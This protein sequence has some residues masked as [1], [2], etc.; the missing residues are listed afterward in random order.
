MA[1]CGGAPRLLTAPLITPVVGL[2]GV[3]VCAEEQG[4]AAVG[5]SHAQRAARQPR[6]VAG[7]MLV[8]Q[9]MHRMLTATAAPQHLRELCASLF[10]PLTCCLRFSS[11]TANGAARVAAQLSPPCGALGALFSRAHPFTPLIGQAERAWRP[12][13]PYNPALQT[14]ATSQRLAPRRCAPPLIFTA[15]ATV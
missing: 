9:A 13:T 15:R 14:P 10:A 6:R 3:Q 1:C 2:C 7:M 5:A 8:S 4:A 11:C 12:R